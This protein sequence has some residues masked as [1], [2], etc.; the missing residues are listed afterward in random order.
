M[1][2]GEE[3][4]PLASDFDIPS[5]FYSIDLLMLVYTCGFVTDNDEGL[6]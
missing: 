6:S 3:L 5:I 1:I 2:M 4:A